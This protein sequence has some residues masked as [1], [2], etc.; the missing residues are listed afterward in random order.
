MTFLKQY[1]DFGI[2]NFIVTWSESEIQRRN[3]TLQTEIWTREIAWIKNNL[4]S[5]YEKV[6]KQKELIEHDFYF[7]IL[8]DAGVKRTIIKKYQAMINNRL[9]R[10]LQTNGLHINFT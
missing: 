1:S 5:T 6:A 8:K 4:Q 7:Q 10:Y 3:I 2:T 9:V